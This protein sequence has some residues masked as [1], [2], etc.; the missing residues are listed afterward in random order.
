MVHLW[1]RIQHIIK[2]NTAGPPLV[3]TFCMEMTRASEIEGIFQPWQSHSYSDAITT[4]H[5]VQ[6]KLLLHWCS[7]EMMVLLS[8]AEI[9][10]SQKCISSWCIMC[11]SNLTSRQHFKLIFSTRTVGEVNLEGRGGGSLGTKGL[12][13]VVEG[14]WQHKNITAWK[15][16]SKSL[17]K[18]KTKTKNPNDKI[19]K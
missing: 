19:T 9:N 2:V 12:V 6:S 4:C 7:T 15:E 16:S 5:S 8:S 3:T 10:Q 14:H 17:M 1:A 13:P 18:L 11:T